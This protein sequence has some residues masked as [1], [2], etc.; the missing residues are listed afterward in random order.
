[1]A[2]NFN[3]EMGHIGNPQ[4]MGQQLGTVPIE[5]IRGFIKRQKRLKG[6][7]YEVPV[8]ASSFD[9]N[10]SGTARLLLGIAVLPKTVSVEGDAPICYCGFSEITAMQLTIN[11]EIVVDTL[12]PNFLTYKFNTNEYYYI[13]R[14]LSGTDQITLKFVNTGANLEGIEVVLYYI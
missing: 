1:M 8:G 14:P 6:Y 4:F 13:P 11:N 5:K 10:L 9:L 7:S 2:D 3:E 12:N